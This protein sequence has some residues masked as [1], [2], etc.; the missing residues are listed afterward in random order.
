MGVFVVVLKSHH[1]CGRYSQRCV[2]WLS[3]Q[4]CTM[5]YG[6]AW[7]LRSLFMQGWSWQKMG[8]WRLLYNCWH[9]WVW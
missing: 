5:L 8:Q 1:L 3:D 4:L 9:R 2:F 7:Q 6:L